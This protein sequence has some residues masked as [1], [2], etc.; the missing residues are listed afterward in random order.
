MKCNIY[1][2]EAL[3]LKE[4]PD[5]MPYL[6]KLIGSDRALLTPYVLK[7]KFKNNSFLDF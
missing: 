2:I 4:R 1:F 7:N 6:I 5:Q 3:V